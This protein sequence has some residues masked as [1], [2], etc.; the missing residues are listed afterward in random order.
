MLK[1]EDANGALA[2]LEKYN[3]IPE[4][5]EKEYRNLTMRRLRRSW[6]NRDCTAY[7]AAEYRIG[8]LLSKIFKT[9]GNLKNDCRI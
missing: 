8:V 6:K 4:D 7:I 2:K 9:A 3:H 5:I 1:Y